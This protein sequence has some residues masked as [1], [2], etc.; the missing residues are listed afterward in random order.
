MAELTIPAGPEALTPE[1]LT[2]AL[3]ETGTIKKSAVTSFDM[4]QDIA[5]GT[6]LIG[7]LARLT[8]HYDQTEEGAPRSL[9]A[10]FPAATPE[11]REIGDLLRF[12]ERE[13]RFYEEIADEIEL[14]TP[15]RYYSAMDIDAK[16]YVLL[17]EDLSQARVGDQLAGCSLAEAEL[18]I[19]ELAKLHATWWDHP[20]LEELD[21]MPKA[22]DPLMAQPVADS[23]QQAWGP[24]REQFGDGPA[25]S[26]LET[27]ERLGE[28]ITAILD[29]TADPPRTIV[30]G[31]CRLDNLFFA[32]KEGGDPLA[33]ID[34]QI[35]LRGRGP[36]DVGYFMSQSIDPS[37]RKAK[38]MDMLRMYHRTL[39]EN[40]VRDYDF[41]QCLH[42]YR[43]STLFCLA[44]PVISGGTLDLANE[45]GLALVTA[46]L[47]RS[48]A[49]I[50]DLNAGE[51][52]PD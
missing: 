9:I 6:G 19:R 42:D 2:Q 45:R 14:R 41:D 17:L 39:M 51:L 33:V 5:A 18:V 12:Y 20:R 46:M 7:Q 21:W 4:E 11:N 22:N 29:Q 10:K 30:H 37:E 15:R 52:L 31:D 47:E 25:R 38:E 13:I 48:V 26:I 1:W 3:R 36:Y 35:S 8:P 32:P 28:K 44:Y 23:Y 34:W 24:F 49:A 50:T 40:G 43:L 16:E 27:G